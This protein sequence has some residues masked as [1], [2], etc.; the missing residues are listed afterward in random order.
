MYPNLFK[1]LGLKLED[2]DK[3]EVP[4]IIGFDGNITVLK[5]T[6]WLP[7]QTGSKVVSVDFIVVDAFSPYTAILAKPWLHAMRGR[8]HLAT[9]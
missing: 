4:L 5:G 8:F 1:S 7:V 6:N 9:F 3:Y 2:L